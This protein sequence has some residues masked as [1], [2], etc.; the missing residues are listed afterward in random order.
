MRPAGCRMTGILSWTADTR[1]V[2]RM[3]QDST[4][5]S[6]GFPGFPKTGKNH[7]AVV[8]DPEVVGRLRLPLPQSLAI[9]RSR[10]QAAAV[11]N[12]LP[13]G[14]L[15]GYRLRPGIY[16]LVAD[17]PLLGPG[18]DQSPLQVIE[19]VPPLGEFPDQ[20]DLLSRCHVIAGKDN[21]A[22]RNTN[23]LARVSDGIC[24]GFSQVRGLQRAHMISG[25]ILFNNG[26]SRTVSKCS[27]GVFLQD[28]VLLQIV[29]GPT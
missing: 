26:K 6:S 19:P 7:G 8:P 2:V 3:V 25:V 5:S 1:P 14:R 24:G 17:R 23:I 29:L 28:R 12:R 22:L 4:V 13:E 15:F 16:H 21:G 9:T 10:H 20:L 18:R 27:G 11:P